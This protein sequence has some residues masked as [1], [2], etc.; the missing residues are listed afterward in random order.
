M[1]G[2]RGQQHSFC[3]VR[4]PACVH[5]PVSV[6]VARTHQRPSAGAALGGT[7]QARSG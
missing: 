5:A 4:L 7:A 6:P 1:T 3:A 2:E